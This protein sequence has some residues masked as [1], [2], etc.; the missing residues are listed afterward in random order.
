MSQ[1][2]PRPRIAPDDPSYRYHTFLLLAVVTG[3]STSISMPTIPV[4]L[5]VALTSVATLATFSLLS[6]RYLTLQRACALRLIHNYTSFSAAS[7]S[8]TIL[9]SAGMG[10]IFQLLLTTYVLS[11]LSLVY[12]VLMRGEVAEWVRKVGG[13]VG[14]WLGA[15]NV[16]ICVV[17]WIM[18]V[19]QEQMTFDFE[20]NVE[21]E[22]VPLK[23]LN[24]SQKTDKTWVKVAS[25]SRRHDIYI[26]TI[27]EGKEF[28]MTTRLASNHP[29]YN[30]DKDGIPSGRILRITLS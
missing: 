25:T 14:W 20:D 24:L 29:L 23:Q 8:K 1:P 17:C 4:M 6:G 22:D 10:T 18:V 12:E 16:T 3:M 2:R 28:E 15:I 19:T 30:P 26:K 27:Q 11:N 7:K 9:T 21:E 5:R 13:A